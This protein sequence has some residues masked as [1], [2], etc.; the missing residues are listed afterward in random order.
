[1][2]FRLRRRYIRLKTFVCG[3]IGLFVGVVLYLLQV[4]FNICRM[5]SFGVRLFILVDL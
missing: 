4:R 1:M 2:P 5:P 3:I